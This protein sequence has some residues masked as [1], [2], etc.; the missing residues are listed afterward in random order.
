[1]PSKYKPGDI[2]YIVENGLT[3]R[4]VKVLKV[5]GEFITLQFTNCR[6]GVRLRESR[7]YP[8]LESAKAVLPKPKRPPHP[9]DIIA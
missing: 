8:D 7:L 3:V 1:M 5:S 2:A 6:G 9:G 4:E